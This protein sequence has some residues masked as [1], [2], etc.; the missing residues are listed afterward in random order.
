MMG[1]GSLKVSKFWTTCNDDG[2][3]IV[4]SYVICIVTEF[5][6]LLHQF[7]HVHFCR[8]TG[9]SLD[10]FFTGRNYFF[11]GCDFDQIFTGKKCFSRPHFFQFS[12]LFTG[13]FYFFTCQI[14]KYRTFFTVA[15]SFF[16]PKQKH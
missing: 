4:D 9:A 5:Q 13:A 14:A 15:F 6:V 1:R 8:F 3:V 16:T 10:F 7:F 11:P 12:E 2:Q